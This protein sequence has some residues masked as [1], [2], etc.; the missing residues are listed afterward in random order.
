MESEAVS[1]TALIQ[2]DRARVALEK[3]STIDEVKDVR[4]Q[5]EALRLYYRQTTEGLEMQNQ[6]AAIKLRAERK[7]GEMLADNPE[8]QRGGS[9]FRDGTLEKLGVEKKQS[10]RWQKVADIPEKEF[11]DYIEDTIASDGEL[12]T[13]G[14]LRRPDAALRVSESNEWY[15]P[16]AYIEAARA[17]LGRIELDPASSAQADVQ[18]RAVKFF[19]KSDD[20]LSQPWH[21]KVWLNPPYGGLSADFTGKLVREHEAGNVTAAVLL[22]NANSTDTAWFQPLWDYLLCF[23][24]GRINFES[25]SGEGVGSTHGSVFAYLPAKDDDG[26]VFLNVFNKLG[27]VVRRA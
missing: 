15:T 14:L 26:R 3:A 5:A 19:D 24:L 10:H 9:K 8:I 2:F 13:A 27:T 7:A 20:G 22:V 4:D 17:V 25:P 23:T 1:D 16:G 6:C 12:T 18:V 11:E 21:G